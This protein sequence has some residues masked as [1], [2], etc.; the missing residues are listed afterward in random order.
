ML[1]HFKKKMARSTTVAAVSSQSF[2][3]T[4]YRWCYVE[5]VDQAAP[6][7]SRSNGWRYTGPVGVTYRRQAVFG[8]GFRI[9]ISFP[10]SLGPGHRWFNSHPLG[11]DPNLENFQTWAKSREEWSIR[12]T[13]RLGA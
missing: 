2:I 5:Q 3:T 8:T 11:G 12:V 10:S 7:A 1:A 6:L 9:R 13:P 4:S